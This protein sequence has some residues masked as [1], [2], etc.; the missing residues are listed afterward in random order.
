MEALEAEIAA[1]TAEKEALEEDL[2]SGTLTGDAL[3]KASTRHGELSGLLDAKET[4]WLEL[5][6]I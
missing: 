4:R 6:L 2:S 1:L 5:S 3:L